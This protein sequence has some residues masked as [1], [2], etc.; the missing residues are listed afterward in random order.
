MR[1]TGRSIASAVLFLIFLPSAGKALDSDF[2]ER[3]RRIA[4]R[5]GYDD[6]YREGFRRGEF[7]GRIHAHFDS[8]C[9]ECE[10]GGMYQ[11]NFRERGHYQKGLRDG[12]R[13]GY[14]SGYRAGESRRHYRR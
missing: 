5:A 11:F 14:R 1:I 4:Y 2:R 7:D 12:Y 6:G 3:D 8:R 10:R 9:R 13:A